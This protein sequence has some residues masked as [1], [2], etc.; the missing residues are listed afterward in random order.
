MKVLHAAT[1]RVLVARIADWEVRQHDPRR[2]AYFAGR[3]FVHVQLWNP[4]TCISVI[5]PSRLT[6]HRFEVADRGGR[7]AFATWGEVRARV[8]ALPGETELAALL[9][10][11]VERYDPHPARASMRVS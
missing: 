6:N 9:G 4:A 5:T 8:A 10:W 11:L 2:F 3:G 7:N 1:D